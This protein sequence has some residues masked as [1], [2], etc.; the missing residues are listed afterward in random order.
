MV[1]MR[2]YRAMDRGF[3]GTWTRT[4]RR[5]MSTA[6]MGVIVVSCGR[7]RATPLPAP[8]GAA[9]ATAPAQRT[10]LGPQAFDA[11]GLFRRLGLLARGAPMPFVGS[12]SFFASCVA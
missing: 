9:A 4:A 5:V 3:S 1:C 12:V 2:V 10:S 8:A 11:I 7:G 6:A